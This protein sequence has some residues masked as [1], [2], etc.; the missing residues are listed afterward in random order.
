MAT[1]G[2]EVPAMNKKSDRKNKMLGKRF[3][4]SLRA[5]YR[6]TNI[7]GEAAGYPSNCRF[8]NPLRTSS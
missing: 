2:V 3:K 7:G 6:M 1:T 5:C 4:V 8:K